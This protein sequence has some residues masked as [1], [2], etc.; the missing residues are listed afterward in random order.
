[1]NEHD[2]TYTVDDLS[3]SQTVKT[4]SGVGQGQL[5]RTGTYVVRTSEKK[6]KSPPLKESPKNKEQIA[7]RVQKTNPA[8]LTSMEVSQSALRTS[9][10]HS[11]SLDKLV[12]PIMDCVSA[13]EKHHQECLNAIFKSTVTNTLISRKIRPSSDNNG[14]NDSQ[15]AEVDA[16]IKELSEEYESRIEKLLSIKRHKLKEFMIVQLR[17]RQVKLQE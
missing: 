13:L 7:D 14:S 1:V 12:D 3:V 17:K 11:S 6:V 5:K 9:R 10:S 15:A 4:R 8:S 16:M 2:T